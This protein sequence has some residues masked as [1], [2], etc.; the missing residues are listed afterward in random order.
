MVG[1]RCDTTSTMSRPIRRSAIGGLLGVLLL[2]EAHGLPCPAA[3]ASPCEAGSCSSDL[4]AETTAGIPAASDGPCVGVT[5]P[6][7]ADLAAAVA[8]HPPDTTFCLSGRHRL[9]APIVPRPGDRFL[10]APSV[11]LDGGGS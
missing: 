8:A 3:A 7:E 9:S 6:E 4:A 2:T 11:T 10:G 1:D 5:V